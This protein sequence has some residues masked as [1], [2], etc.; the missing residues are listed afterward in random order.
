MNG[1]HTYRGLK[2]LLLI[3]FFPFLLNAQTINEAKEAFNN[4]V[5]ANSSNNLEEAIKQFNQVVS[6]CNKLQG[7]QEAKSLLTQT[8]GLLPKLNLQLAKDYFQNKN[9]DK[10]VKQFQTAKKVATTYNDA[11][12]AKEATDA[13]PQVYSQIG[14][15]YYKKGDFQNAVT[16]FNNAANANPQFAAAYYYLALTYSKLNNGDKVKESA[17]KA[18]QLTK[19]SNN[20]KLGNRVEDVAATY[21]LEKANKAKGSA[22]YED[23]IKYVKQSLVYKNDNATAYY[24]LAAVQNSLSNW[25]EAIEAANNA[26]KYEVDNNVKKAKDYFEL[27]NAYKGKQEYPAA[28]EAFKKASYGAFE[29]S[30]KYQIK[31]VL[32]C[33]E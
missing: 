5:T 7:D 2:L 4:G 3:L 33:G 8:E 25:D 24:L 6:I 32:K 11:A 18:L 28:C 23:A 20:S 31:Y 1:E 22:K 30:A 17:D 13:I 29:Q 9:F 12:T 27:G 14:I 19:A 26:L 15:D 16:Q 21:F 10:A